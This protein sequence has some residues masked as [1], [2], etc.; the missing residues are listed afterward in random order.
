MCGERQP[1]DKLDMRG[2]LGRRRR[3]ERRS[4][5]GLPLACWSSQHTITG[6]GRLGLLTQ[7]S[8]V[9]CD[10]RGKDSAGST[11]D[12]EWSFRLQIRPM[13]KR[14]CRPARARAE[15]LTEWAATYWARRCTCSSSIEFCGLFSPLWFAPVSAACVGKGSGRRAGDKS[16]LYRIVKEHGGRF[17][18]NWGE[19]DVD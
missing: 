8:V 14:T 6:E 5:A 13:R 15:R 11:L 19:Y 12:D 2:Q 10:V 4:I 3:W 7:F 1:H 9:C 18:M 16:S 17:H